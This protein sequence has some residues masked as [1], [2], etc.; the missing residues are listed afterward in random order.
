M[1]GDSLRPWGL[2]P[3]RIL[4]KPDTAP[5]GKPRGELP[6]FLRKRQSGDDQIGFPGIRHVA[7]YFREAHTLPP[8]P[9][10]GINAGIEVAGE[11]FGKA[12]A[13]RLHTFWGKIVLEYQITV[14]PEAVDGS[15][16]I[17]KDWQ[18]MQK[19]MIIWINRA[20]R[21]I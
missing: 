14:R 21:R 3:D 6:H 13:K 12:A 18:C 4:A 1:I 8:I 7:S 15:A 16:V 9:F 19:A 17:N 10:V 5:A 2:P 11:E 20:D